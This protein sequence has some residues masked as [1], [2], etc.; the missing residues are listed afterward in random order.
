MKKIIIILNLIISVSL[1]AQK[2]VD[3]KKHGIKD[4]KIWSEVI[5]ADRLYEENSFYNAI[6]VYEGALE[7]LPDNEYLNFKV[8]MSYYKARDYK[9]AARAFAKSTCLLYTSPSPRDA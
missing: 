3:G 9:N 8:G 4:P 5:K 7:K 6:G 1:I 2:S